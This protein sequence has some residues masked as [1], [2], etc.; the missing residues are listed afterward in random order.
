MRPPLS[1]VHAARPTA[2]AINEQIR[3]LM[4]RPSSE[5][6][7][8]E[9]GRLLARWAEAIAPRGELAALA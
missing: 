9:Y 7:T 5:E 1:T 3:R 8:E 4:D 6:R 2:I